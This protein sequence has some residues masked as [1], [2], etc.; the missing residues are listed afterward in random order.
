MCSGNIRIFNYL[1]TVNLA[2]FRY[3]DFK[4]LRTYSIIFVF[5]KFSTYFRHRQF[6]YH[7]VNVT[8]RLSFL[9]SHTPRTPARY[10]IP[11]TSYC[12]K[13]IV[14]YILEVFVN[15]SLKFKY[16]KIHS[17]KNNSDVN[18]IASS[19]KYYFLYQL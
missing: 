4:I 1:L 11:S 17:F 9:I 10:R 6:W 13:S 5:S 14:F 8:I 12:F 2:D 19:V 7:A 15:V 16:F 3:I 18:K